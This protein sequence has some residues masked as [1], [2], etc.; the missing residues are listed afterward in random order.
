EEPSDDE[1]RKGVRREQEQ[2]E[3]GKQDDRLGYVLEPGGNDNGRN[4]EKR[5]E[6]ESSCAD[7]DR[8]PHS[9]ALLER[10]PVDVG[11]AAAVADREHAVLAEL[12][13]G[14]PE[15]G[16]AQ[17]V[18]VANGGLGAVKRFVDAHVWPVARS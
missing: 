10:A 9:H 18:S 6:S 15:A 3:P 14:G 5:A 2:D 12:S 4:A 17:A 11:D 8:Q 13:N 1:V 7:S 16:S